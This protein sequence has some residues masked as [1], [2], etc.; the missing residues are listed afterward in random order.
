MSIFDRAEIADWMWK[1]E[2]A[3]LDEIAEIAEYPAFRN[4]LYGRN[5]KDPSVE[6]GQ[7]D[8]SAT[9]NLCG[10]GSD[11]AIVDMTERH[12][13]LGVFRW[14]MRK[15]RYAA[16]IVPWWIDTFGKPPGEDAWHEPCHDR[17]TLVKENHG[18]TDILRHWDSFGLHQAGLLGLRFGV[19]KEEDVTSLAKCLLDWLLGGAEKT[20]QTQREYIRYGNRINS[21]CGIWDVLNRPGT[22]AHAKTAWH[23]LKALVYYAYDPANLTH[24]QND[25]GEDWPIYS[26]GQ[27]MYDEHQQRWKPAFPY[28]WW[29]YGNQSWYVGHNLIGLFHAAERAAWQ[30]DHE[31][32]AFVVRVLD[33]QTKWLD[34]VDRHMAPL[35]HANDGISFSNSLIHGCI[36]KLANDPYLTAQNLHIDHGINSLRMLGPDDE[37]FRFTF[38]NHHEADAN[39]YHST[40][41]K[42]PDGV[43]HDRTAFRYEEGYTGRPNLDL[44]NSYGCT[45]GQFI[46]ALLHPSEERTD[47]SYIVPMSMMGWGNRSDC[48]V[49]VRDVMDPDDGVRGYNLI[50]GHTRAWH[51]WIQNGMNLRRLCIRGGKPTAPKAGHLDA[52]RQVA[53]DVCGK[54]T[55]DA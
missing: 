41:I 33:I 37:F 16:S 18:D 48:L 21:L 1:K 34:V 20:T 15:V 2:R 7:C 24:V 13:H 14:L 19:A 36:H 26:Y 49:R 35:A 6:F 3:V 22:L 25:E 53:A 4:S 43:E 28:G 40:I 51:W 23:T 45:E 17:T 12:Q 5:G 29:P 47:W 39:A 44:N 55:G 10:Y 31:F 11:Q 32:L 9:W 50:G 54:E 8:G 42:D 27:F 38:I 30:G 52:M 46:R